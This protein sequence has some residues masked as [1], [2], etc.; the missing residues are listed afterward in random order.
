MFDLFLWA[1]I[2]IAGFFVLIKSSDYFVNSA[3]KVGIHFGMPAFIVGVTIVSIG[4]SLPELLVS[5]I[6]VF[7]G[8]SEIV[9]GNI[10]GSNI[11]NI[12]LVLGVTAIVGR[13]IRITY[14]ISKIDLPLLFGSTFLLA[15]CAWD[16]AFTFFE[17]LLCI[18]GFLVYIFYTISVEKKHK[19]KEIKKELNG[20][21]RKK[22]L[23]PKTWIIMILSVFFIFVGSKLVVESVIN[24]SELLNIG[25]GVIAAT[26]VALGTSLPELTVSVTAAIKHKPEMA[27]GNILGS[28]IFNALAIVGVSG[29]FGTLLVPANIISF[30]IPMMIIAT[31]LYVFMTQDKFVS[32]WEGWLLICFYIFFIGKLF[33]LF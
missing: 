21:L 22:K 19:D 16:G 7:R 8:A 27:I 26:V 1:I 13:K 33:G 24:L 25:T 12:F 4:T 18:A 29:L 31:F 32:K 5:I 23:E 2:F 28:N 20:A 6:S 14:E 3:E 11:T 17:A 30:G 10:V 15:V 9:I